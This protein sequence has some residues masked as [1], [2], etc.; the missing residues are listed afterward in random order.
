M[1]QAD[2]QGHARA[3]LEK[4][5]GKTANCENGNEQHEVQGIYTKSLGFE[6][7]LKSTVPEV[8]T[9]LTISVCCINERLKMSLKNRPYNHKIRN[10]QIKYRKKTIFYI[11]EEN[12]MKCVFCM[13]VI[14]L[15][16]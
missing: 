2:L 3:N 10:E 7:E 1:I 15:M 14:N 16:K 9:Y 8:R 11:R 12:Y 6:K 13:Q 5:M 4:F